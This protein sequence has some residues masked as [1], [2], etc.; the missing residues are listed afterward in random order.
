MYKRAKASAFALFNGRLSVKIL[1]DADGCPVTDIT[2]SIA[3]ENGIE[4]ILI[5]DTSH[6]FDYS[7]V[8]VIIVS[9]GA[10]SADFVLVNKVE[11]NDIIITQDYGLAAMCL[12]KG[13]FVVNQNGYEYTNDN[14][15]TMLLKRHISKKVRRAGGKNSH[16]KKRTKEDNAKFEQCLNKVLTKAKNMV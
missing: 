14:I 5:C 3:K 13:G 15:D 1:I 2:I 9:K 8:E 11:K 10:D 4:V 6:I 12:A 16:I 7:G